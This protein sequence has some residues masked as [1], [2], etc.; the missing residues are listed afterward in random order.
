MQGLRVVRLRGPGADG[1]A[2]LVAA[3]H[4]VRSEVKADESLR[5]SL[6]PSNLFGLLNTEPKAQRRAEKSRLGCGIKDEEA[7][8]DS[9][10]H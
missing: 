2:S 4:L 10:H 3:G 8:H 9:A 1:L 5:A 6:P 7:L